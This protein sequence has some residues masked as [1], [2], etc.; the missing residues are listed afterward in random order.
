MDTRCSKTNRKV[1]TM[2]L[3]KHAH[4]ALSACALVGVLLPGCGGK[5]NDE[6]PAPTKDAMKASRE[7]GDA[8]TTDATATPAAN[9]AS[10]PSGGGSLANPQAPG[11]GSGK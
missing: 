8:G 5:A 9:G 2:T 6:T 1:S 4:L 11:G 3:R 10:T 7:G